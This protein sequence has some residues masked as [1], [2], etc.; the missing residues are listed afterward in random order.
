[1]RADLGITVP[2]KSKYSRIFAKRGTEIPEDDIQLI[3]D[4]IQERQKDLQDA[5]VDNVL[6]M[7]H[8]NGLL[9]LEKRED[10]VI[11]EHDQKKINELSGKLILSKIDLANISERDRQI[12][13]MCREMKSS[14]EIGRVVHLAPKSVDNRLSELRGIFGEDVVPRRR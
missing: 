9:L 12:V 7:L 11:N 1:M 13:D 14:I 3:Q 2:E 4:L 8:S 10:D 5:I 6:E